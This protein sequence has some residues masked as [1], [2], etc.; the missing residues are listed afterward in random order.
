VG[1]DIYFIQLIAEVNQG[2]CINIMNGVI[3]KGFFGIEKTGD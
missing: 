2:S 1:K 3:G